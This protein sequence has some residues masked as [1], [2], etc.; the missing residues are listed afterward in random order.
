VAR[1]VLKI[2]GLAM[3]ISAAGFL[4]PGNFER[5]FR[6]AQPGR[7]HSLREAPSDSLP[8]DWLWGWKSAENN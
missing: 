2:V 5:L 1:R 3:E 7:Y 4:S 6:D 8:A